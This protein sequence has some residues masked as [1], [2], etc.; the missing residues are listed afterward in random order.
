MRFAH[1]D[2]LRLPLDRAQISQRVHEPLSRDAPVVGD[3]AHPVSA[4]RD[5]PENAVGLVSVIHR[6]VAHEK[7]ITRL[8]ALAADPKL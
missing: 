6:Q 8:P 4:E 7:K 5:R 2:E 1:G 3:Q